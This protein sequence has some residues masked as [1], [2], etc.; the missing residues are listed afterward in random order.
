MRIK[1]RR[2]GRVGNEPF[3]KRYP[4]GQTAGTIGFI[5]RDAR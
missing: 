2:S 1:P 5:V 4:P 3:G